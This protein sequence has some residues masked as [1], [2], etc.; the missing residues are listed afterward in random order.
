MYFGT[1]SKQVEHLRQE[2][3]SIIGA[4]VSNLP[5]ISPGLSTLHQTKM[6]RCLITYGIFILFLFVAGCAEGKKESLAAKNIC[7]EKQLNKLRL[8]R[9]YQEVMLQFKAALPQLATDKGYFGVQGLANSQ[10]DDAIFFSADSSHCLALLLQ[11]E[12]DSVMFGSA[13]VFLGSQAGTWTFRPLLR[14]SFDPDYFKIYKDNS[15]KEIGQVARYS[16]L[17]EGKGR[18][19]DCSPDEEYW[20]NYQ[21]AAEKGRVEKPGN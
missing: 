6:S 10:V 12:K 3:M 4:R 1:I 16:I 13:V 17:S 15:F 7:Y 14:Y 9:R 19:T 20:F 21:P 2:K 18:Q 5:A 8:Q 11:D